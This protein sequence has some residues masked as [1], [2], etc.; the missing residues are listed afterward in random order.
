MRSDGVR[1]GVEEY[2]AANVNK[3]LETL[4][5]INNGKDAGMDDLLKI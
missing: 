3:K 4:F 5:W 2:I 1:V